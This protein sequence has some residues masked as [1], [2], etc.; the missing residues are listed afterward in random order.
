MKQD[1]GLLALITIALLG[2]QSIHASTTSQMEIMNLAAGETLKKLQASV[3]A[4][5]KFMEESSQKRMGGVIG[6]FGRMLSAV[7]PG[8]SKQ[9]DPQADLD[10]LAGYYQAMNYADIMALTFLK[11]NCKE[12]GLL[13]PSTDPVLCTSYVP[14]LVKSIEGRIG[15][16]TS[17][18]LYSDEILKAP[19]EWPEHAL[20]ILRLLEELNAAEGNVEYGIERSLIKAM[21]DKA[22]GRVGNEFLDV[23]SASPVAIMGREFIA[24][25]PMVNTQSTMMNA[26]LPGMIANAGSPYGNP[27]VQGQV[28]QGSIMGQQQG[29]LPPPPPMYQ[30]QAVAQGQVVGMPN[31]P[32]YPNPYQNY[33]CDRGMQMVP[34][35]M[36]PAAAF[37]CSNG[38]NLDDR[39]SINS[40]GA[41][42]TNN[43]DNS[44]SSNSSNSINSSNNSNSS[45]TI[46]DTTSNPSQSSSVP[47][48]LTPKS[49]SRFSWLFGSKK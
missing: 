39:N 41:V 19:S 48:T 4:K 29:Y 32:Y 24:A 5:A 14:L 42:Y 43:I 2:N 40:N 38:G 22:D 49:K 16:V 9:A 13:V 27:V 7:L 12:S 35:I 36:M 17:H 46:S 33:P 34:M 31:N 8:S 37:P 10:E 23:P 30:G 28:V 15:T 44:N 47:G 26:G 25:S 45:N 6:M 18:Y 20:E 1:I 11:K 3:V 21:K